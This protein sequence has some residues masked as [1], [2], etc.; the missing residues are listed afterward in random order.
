LIRL[1]TSTA[2]CQWKNFQWWSVGPWTESSK[3]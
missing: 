1:I 3:R 2:V